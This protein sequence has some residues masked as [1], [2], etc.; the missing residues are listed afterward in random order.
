MPP[1]A[2]IASRCVELGGLLTE[3]GQHGASGQVVVLFGLEREQLVAR[4]LDHAPAELGG[5]YRQCVPQIPAVHTEVVEPGGAVGVAPSLA[6]LPVVLIGVEQVDQGRHQPHRVEGAEAVAEAAL[7]PGEEGL[8]VHRQAVERA[9]VAGMEEVGHPQ[10][11]GEE[12]RIGQVGPEHG[13]A[14]Q[15]RAPASHPRRPGGD[16][17]RAAGDP[18]SVGPE[19]SGSPSVGS[20]SGWGERSVITTSGGVAESRWSAGTVAIALLS[21]SRPSLPRRRGAALRGSGRRRRAGLR[22]GGTTGGGDRAGGHRGQQSTARAR[23]SGRCSAGGGCPCWRV[24]ARGV[25]AAGVSR[26]RP[27]W[28][29]AG[30]RGAGARTA[31]GGR[32]VVRNRRRRDRPDPGDPCPGHRTTYRRPWRSPAR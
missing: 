12:G 23:G 3:G 4:G 25:A 20:S 16:G 17:A 15:V 1:S 11:P 21:P 5:R 30:D 31:P 29:G 22:A 13:P 2:P 18:G 28:S 19:G 32:V 10:L 24:P 8:E 14:R 27:T 6:P 9:A 7:Q 26:P